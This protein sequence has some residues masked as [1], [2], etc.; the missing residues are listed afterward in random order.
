MADELFTKKIAGHIQ[1]SGPRGQTHVCAVKNGAAN[2]VIP[3]T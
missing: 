2:S 3:S 1:M